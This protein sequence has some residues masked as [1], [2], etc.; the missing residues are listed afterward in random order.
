MVHDLYIKPSQEYH[1][2]TQ[3]HPNRLLKTSRDR[4]RNNIW[5][6]RLHDKTQCAVSD[7]TGVSHTKLIMQV[8]VLFI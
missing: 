5:R 4:S 2:M 6:L 3:E 7:S 8:H 1:S